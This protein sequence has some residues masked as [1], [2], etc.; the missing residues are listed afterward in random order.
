MTEDWENEDCVGVMREPDALEQ[1]VAAEAYTHGE[2]DRA[3]G[4]LAGVL[5]TTAGTSNEQA[6]QV[7]EGTGRSFLYLDLET[8]P[9]EERMELFEFPPL[10]E[11]PNETTSANCPPP[12]ELLEMNL[13]GL[14]AAIGTL[15]PDEA[16]LELL[17]AQEKKA[18]KPRAGVADAVKRWAARKRE[19]AGAEDDRRKAMATCPEMCRI[20]A[21]GWALGDGAINSMV[22]GPRQTEGPEWTEQDLLEM[23]WDLAHNNGP[24][25]GFNVLGFDLRVIMARSILLDVAPT[26]QLSLS[27]FGRGQRDV[28]DLMVERFG[29]D[30]PTGLKK[31]AKLYGISVPAGQTNGGDVGRLIAE[32]RHD[33]VGE[34]V[35]SDVQVTRD[36]H[37]KF[38]GYFSL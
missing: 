23:F 36:L 1:A 16:Y 19:V 30:R 31:L 8:V 22:T 13:A 3:A 12:A 2:I 20:V 17:A 37:R 9:D 14:E 33:L 32:G 26:K 15:N 11:L 27:P 38:Q 6:A 28:V 34:Y 18:M 5:A 29:R 4:L 7:I 10:P 21:I 25:V 35:R 24:I